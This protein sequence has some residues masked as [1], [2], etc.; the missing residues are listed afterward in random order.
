MNP[1]LN[2]NQNELVHIPQSE[3]E[4]KEINKLFEEP[5]Q[6]ITEKRKEPQ[7]SDLLVFGAGVDEKSPD[8][9]SN[10]AKMRVLAALELWR[11]GEVGQIIFSGGKTNP[12]IDVSEAEAMRRYFLKMFHLDLEAS[13][14]SIEQVEEE[15]DG[16]ENRLINEDRATNTLENVAQT[17]EIFSRDRL[18]NPKAHVNVAGL[19]THFHGARI[20]EIL[21]MFDIN[22]FVFDEE[23]LM[24]IRNPKFRDLIDKFRNNPSYEKT[25]QA[26]NRWMRGLEQEPDYYLQAFSLIDDDNLFQKAIL[27]LIQSHPARQNIKTRLEEVGVVNIETIN[28]TQLRQIIKSIIRIKPPESWASPE[29]WHQ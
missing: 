16:A 11:R 9:L 27:K 22:A 5:G 17:M 12:K 1:E 13:K 20:K 24:E 29:D 28:P 21:K 6:S 18:K 25:L 2:H 3:L 26:E 10:G 23:F 4:L 15:I 14:I 7:Y 19:S 8:L